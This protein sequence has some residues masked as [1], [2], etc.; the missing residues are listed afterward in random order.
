ME[1]MEPPSMAEVRLAASSL[2]AGWPLHPA[3]APTPRVT[4]RA[5]TLAR[6]VMSTRRARRGPRFD[7]EKLRD[8]TLVETT[9]WM[10]NGP[11]ST[12]TDEAAARPS[13]PA[14]HQHRSHPLDALGAQ[15]GVVAPAV[16]QRRKALPGER[17]QRP[18]PHLGLD[19]ALDHDLRE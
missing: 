4:R 9:P 5:S 15:P 3:R 18:P 12:F 2:P 10:D 6:K 14:L 19:A 8:G 13:I 16:D 7:P 1:A 11:P 17:E